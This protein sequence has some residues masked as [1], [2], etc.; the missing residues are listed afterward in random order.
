ML[1]ASLRIS[2]LRLALAVAS[3]SSTASATPADLAREIV[4]EPHAGAT[5]EDAAIRA[6]QT[7]ADAAD[8]TAADF[9]K[10]GWAFVAKARRTLDAGFHALAEKTA[11]TV[12]ARFGASAGSR[13]LRGHAL[14]NLHRFTEA[15]SLGRALAAERGTP[16]DL[17]L[18]SDALLELGRT[19]EA[20]PVLQRLV[21]AKPGVEAHSRIAHVRWLKGD[22]A[23]ATAAMETAF[24][25]TSPRDAEGNAWALTR[26]AGFYLQAG[27]SDASLAAAEAALAH[28]GDFPPA[29][30]GRGRALLALGHT[31]ASLAPLT[32]AAELNPL[33]EYQWWL[34]DALRAAGTTSAIA[35]AAAVEAALLSR[36]EASDPRTLALFLATRGRDAARAVRLA[37]EELA[38]RADPFTH[39]ALAWALAASGD[40][41]AAATASR[42]ALAEGTRDARLLW[43]AGEIALARGA[44]DEARGYFEQAQPMAATLTPSERTRLDARLASHLATL[45]APA[46]PAVARVAVTP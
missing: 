29:L 20:I 43:H 18:W 33:P 35:R 24:R 38:Q 37:R 11:D 14:H 45:S 2:L 17:A 27:R 5:P 19:A 25:A 22:L 39:D 42:A 3:G 34:A 12:D 31:E 8:A 15:E 23:G 16:A 44:A 40:H 6:A 30:L 13:L 26:L 4:L 10:L 41:A 36:G 9:E 7:R 1:A 21:D 46:A 32:R 28:A